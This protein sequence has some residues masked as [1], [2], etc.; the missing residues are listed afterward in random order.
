MNFEDKKYCTTL[1]SISSAL[2]SV[3]FGYPLDVI[4]TRMQVSYHRSFSDCLRLTVKKDGFATLYRGII[5]VLF[6]AAV[7]RS[8]SIHWYISGKD[9]YRSY[10]WNPNYA[11][12]FGGLYCG[13]LSSLLIG[14]F[15]CFKVV[16]QTSTMSA[17]NVIKSLHKMYGI[18]GFFIGF[19]TQ[20]CRDLL[21]TT[22]YFGVYEYSNNYLKDKTLNWQRFMLSGSLSGSLAWI[23]IFPLDVVKSNIQRNALKYKTSWSSVLKHRSK[24]GKPY[25]FLYRGLSPTLLRTIPLHA[26]NFLIY[27]NVIFIC[28]GEYRKEL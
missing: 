19:P 16:R 28:S 21:A 4:K 10:G 14:P 15:E 7:T 25:S 5:P 12:F 1:A 6:T 13:L 20:V 3:T 24:E 23:L 26:L 27:E 9:I 11:S 18:R 2:M 8:L 17:S 22:T